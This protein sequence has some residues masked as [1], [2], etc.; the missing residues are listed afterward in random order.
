MWTECARIGLRC[1][2]LMALLV[3][4]VVAGEYADKVLVDKSNARLY[5][6]RSGQIYRSFPVVFGGQPKGH[7][8]QQGDERTPEGHYTLDYKNPHSSYYKSIHISYPNS[9]DR[10]RARAKGV[11][12][13]GEIMI[14]GQKNGFGWLAAVTQKYNWT[15]GC[16]ALSNAD[17]D[18]VWQAVKVGTPIEIRP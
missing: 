14:H 1:L 15:N 8:Q 3:A 6:L 7:K 18:A 11:N 4:D 10:Q 17:M 13:G 2:L 16:I 12:P 9:A 5:L